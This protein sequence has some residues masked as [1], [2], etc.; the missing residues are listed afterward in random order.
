MGEGIG[1]TVAIDRDSNTMPLLPNTY[2]LASLEQGKHLRPVRVESPLP[3]LFYFV[4]DLTNNAPLTVHESFLTPTERLPYRLRESNFLGVA[5]ILGAA[6][7]AFPA[8]IIVN[9]N[10]LMPGTMT[11]RLREAIRAKLLQGYKHPTIDES[12]W[13]TIGQKLQVSP[14]PDCV[15]IGSPEAIK[16]HAVP[17]GKVNGSF[18]RPIGSSNVPTITLTSLEPETLERLCRLLH[19]RAFDPT[20]IVNLP[21][22]SPDLIESLESRY[23][24][25]FV[26]LSETTMQIIT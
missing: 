17:V 11:R 24:L 18:V 10:P 20:P 15:F 21:T 4:T 8:I 2:C 6:V 16:A 9:P 19:D 26:P 1:L 12:K 5:H 13:K 23:D 3:G 7:D 14:Q 22:L 25:G